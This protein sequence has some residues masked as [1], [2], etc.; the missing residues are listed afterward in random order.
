M[1]IITEY[2]KKL[3]LAR[4]PIEFV[5][6]LTIIPSGTKAE[7]RLVIHSLPTVGK[8]VNLAMYNSDMPNFFLVNTLAIAND[9]KYTMIPVPAVGMNTFSYASFLAN[10]LKNNQMLD[11]AFVITAHQNHVIFTARQFGAQFQLTPATQGFDISGQANA[12][13]DW[14]SVVLTQPYL[15]PSD[16]QYPTGM[17]IFYEKVFGSNNFEEVATVNG[18]NIGD[19][20]I[21]WNLQEYVSAYFADAIDKPNMNDTSIHLCLNITKRFRFFLLS[22]G[23]FNTNQ[24]LNYIA[25]KGG[26][27]S[28]HQNNYKDIELEFSLNKKW[29]AWQPSQRVIT[30]EQPEFLYYF[31]WFERGGVF[32]TDINGNPI[33]Q[34][35]TVNIAIKRYYDD[36]TFDQGTLIGETF[37][38]QGQCAYVRVDY[39][40]VLP[41]ADP[42]KTLIA[43]EVW[44]W[45]DNQNGP[46]IPSQVQITS[47]IFYELTA[48]PYKQTFFLYENSWGAWETLRAEGNQTGEFKTDIT[49]ARTIRGLNTFSVKRTKKPYTLEYSHMA[50]ADSQEGREALIDFLNSENVVLWIDGQEFPVIINTESATI[51]E[52]DDFTYILPF[53]FEFANTEINFSR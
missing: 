39:D 20:V 40:R 53:N 45:L 10:W 27:S 14:L 4:N 49:K 42:A 52:E 38:A 12:A 19:G 6:Q 24:P 31:M 25:L 16:N 41:G 17:I 33:F 23:Q 50:S 13:Y 28:R 43:W 5:F 36:D 15:S 11:T 21:R 3:L 48:S 46:G 47:P 8:L 26:V 35:D 30:R 32:T 44:A 51:Y 2:P 9:N 37:T 22:I 34:Y 29:L 1:A 18:I 7:S